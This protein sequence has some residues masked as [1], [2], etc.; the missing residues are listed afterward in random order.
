M[1][2]IR[3]QAIT[4]GIL[5]YFG[6]LIGAINIFLFT[7]NGAF[8]EEQFGL[9][10]IFFD[11]AQNIAAFGTLGVTTVLYKFH[12]Y[13]KD[14]LP[15][16]QND[17]FTWVFTA[18]IIGFALVL[19]FGWQFQPLMVRKFSRGS[20]LFLDY[21]YWVFPF[22]LG[23]LLFSLF[24]V[25]SNIIQQSV[26]PNFLKETALRIFTT[27]LIGCFYFKLISFNW[28]VIL[29]SLL[30]LVL[31][32]I[33]LFFLLH[34]KAF[35]LTFRVSRVTK[36]FWKKMV[37]M[38]LLM[39]T[40]TVIQ[41]LSSTLDGILIAS[42][43]T[44][45]IAGIFT[46]AQYVANLVQVP[47][48][49]LQSI[50]V[51]VLLQAWKENNRAEVMRIYARSSINMLIASLF[52]YGNVVLNT[53]YAIEA[54]GIKN[55]YLAGMEA[56]IILGLVRVL[57]AG[58]GVNNI[59]ILTSS[60]WRFDFYSGLILLVLIAPT[61]YIFIKQ[62][63][64]VGSA[65]AQLLSF[66]IYNFIRWNFIRKK[67]DMQPFNKQTLYTILLSVFGFAIAYS[68]CL[69]LTGWLGIILRSCIFSGMMIGGIFYWQLTPDAGQLW[70]KVKIKL[71]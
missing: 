40:G 62:Y 43:K 71:K 24:E 59:V 28:F 45:Q 20:Q 11:F 13:Y 1:S 29:F 55:S 31:V 16:K 12:P 9:T 18:A 7:K 35:T 36:K 46:L 63:G 27:L 22:G 60:H 17:L 14:N 10:R 30:Y 68:T 15:F 47:Q 32:S 33:L 54:I 19:F 44:I 53:A 2:T 25:M 8:T 51:G 70:E 52:I 57:D 3:K 58:T 5:L 39:F 42:L 21:Y 38:Q 64:I 41:A 6:F 34:K 26:M 37:W 23:M 4:S 56:M 69:T 50:T 67:F 65:Y 66:I 61:N 49:S 48:R